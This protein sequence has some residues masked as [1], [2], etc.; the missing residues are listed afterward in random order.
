[1]REFASTD[2]GGFIG[3]H[4]RRFVIDEA[5]R[6]PDL[7]SYIQTHVDDLGEQGVYVLKF[8]TEL[9]QDIAVQP[10]IV[11]AGAT[12]QPRKGANVLAWKSFGKSVPEN[13]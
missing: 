3:V 6:V 2:P 13:I 1:M 4:T 5:Q 7:F 9:S 8:Y 12:D 10:T 11:Y